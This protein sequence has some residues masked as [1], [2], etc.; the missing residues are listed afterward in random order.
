MKLAYFDLETTG[1]EVDKA[2]IV[3]VAIIT[4]SGGRFSS[5][6]NPEI[7]IPPEATE[8][9]GITDEMVAEAPT[10]GVVAL[11]VLAILEGCVLVGYNSHAYDTPVL[12]HEL[13][14]VGLKHDLLERQE[15]DLFNLWR[16]QEPRTLSGAL[17]RF[18]KAKNEDAHEAMADTQDLPALLAS[19]MEVF[20]IGTLEDA[21]TL[22]IDPEELD[23]AGKFVRGEDGV[24]RFN[25]GKH[26][27]SAVAHNM[28]YLD[29][30][31]GADFPTETKHY[32]RLLK[33]RFAKSRV[34]G[35]NRSH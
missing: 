16:T 33:E 7:P 6:V 18:L 12:A 23:R 13:D 32:C 25:F 15:I 35:Q 4:S 26:K 31:L 24:V 17:L 20:G 3:Q 28:S 10:F 14:R 11:K 2:R 30:M 9:H 8:I 5:H 29:W 27:G 34:A 21:A 22:S 19:M 1:K